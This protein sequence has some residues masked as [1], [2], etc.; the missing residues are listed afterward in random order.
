[1]ARDTEVCRIIRHLRFFYQ[2][3]LGEGENVLIWGLHAFG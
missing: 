3:Y 1:M 2:L